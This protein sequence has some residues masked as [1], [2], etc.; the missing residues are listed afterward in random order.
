MQCAKL[1]EINDQLFSF[2]SNNSD[3]R[4]KTEKLSV[5]FTI[6]KSRTAL[7]PASIPA[8]LLEKEKPICVSAEEC[9]TAS[10]MHMQAESRERGVGAKA[11][12]QAKKMT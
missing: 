11:N 10:L 12:T 9:G 5:Q 1:P 3:S 2:H 4:L 7:F 8:D 6:L